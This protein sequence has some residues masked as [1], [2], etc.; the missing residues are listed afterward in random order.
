MY[1]SYS[2]LCF[3]AC[4]SAHTLIFQHTHSD[5]A[6]PSQSC[7]RFDELTASHLHGG[8]LLI[9]KREVVREVCSLWGK[10]TPKGVSILSP[11]SF[12]VLWQQRHEQS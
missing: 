11:E 7:V 9:E 5:T 3:F 4:N 1:T 6:T 10:G 2:A 8:N 12:Q